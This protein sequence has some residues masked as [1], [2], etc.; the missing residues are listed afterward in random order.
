MARRR[1]LFSDVETPEDVEVTLRINLFEIV[2]QVTPATHQHQK[3]APTGVVLLVCPKVLG[4]PV[5]SGGQ[6]SDLDFR[7]PR[8][9]VGTPK[10]SNQLLFPLSGYGHLLPRLLYLGWLDMLLTKHD[11]PTMPA[12]T[13]PT[14]TC[15]NL[16]SMS[17]YQLPSALQPRIG[18]AG[19]ENPYLEIF[20]PDERRT[21]GKTGGPGR[22]CRQSCHTSRTIRDPLGTPVFSLFYAPTNHTPPKSAGTNFRPCRRK[23][24][25][26]MML[27][28][29][30]RIRF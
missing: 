20:W 21:P 25:F 22:C 18:P 16:H 13:L 17:V 23:S 11:P 10:I 2:Q 29:D 1:S 24:R 26:N 19:Q 6:N 12:K 15:N 14:L 8:I 27:R 9:V 30:F 3:A 28:A 5:Y 7:R 4:Q